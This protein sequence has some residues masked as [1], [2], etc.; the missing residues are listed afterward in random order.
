MTQ[1]HTND[2]APVPQ[3]Q[4]AWAVDKLMVAGNGVASA[5]IGVFAP[6]ND[7]LHNW[8]MW[9]DVDPHEAHGRAERRCIELCGDRW[10]EIYELWQMW[11]ALMT[12]REK[13]IPLHEA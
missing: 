5:L 1:Q 8:D 2:Y 6:G 12:V 9:K 4:L 7:D 3:E 11:Y 13:L 10:Y